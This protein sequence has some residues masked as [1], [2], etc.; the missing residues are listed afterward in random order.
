VTSGPLVVRW[1]D[2][3]LGQEPPQA[4]V[5]QTA[6]VELENAGT[7]TWRTRGAE[8]GLFLSYHWLDERGNAIVWDGIRTPL[9]R[10]VAPGERIRHSLMLR[11]PIPPGRYRL[12]LDLVEEH[13]FW[14]AEVGNEP[15][16]Q[17]LDVVAR[18]ASSARAFLGEGA[19]GD[20]WHERVRALHEEGYSAV[21]GAIR[22]E[23]GLLRRVDAELE[24]YEPGGGRNPAF[25]YPL[26]C[27]SLM[28]PL[29]PNT[30]V[31]GL[32]AWRPEGGEP[33]MYDARMEVRL[34]SRSGRRR[35]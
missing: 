19:P 29:E 26:V 21:G 1:L 22:T 8:D 4:G 25:G 18:D 33:W 2:L 13:R 5:L 32:P 20:G 16:E 23:R 10:A 11:G 28:P 6:R 35:A 14:L 7:A 31:A 9:E 12:A 24:P 15:L 27:P 3:E 17:D 34:R 30:T